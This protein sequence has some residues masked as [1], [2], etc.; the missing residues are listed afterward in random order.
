MM[1]DQIKNKRT[2]GEKYRK[3]GTP[4][5]IPREDRLCQC[6]CGNSFKCKINSKQR[7]ISGHN[8]RGEHW[9]QEV[10]D[11]ISDGHKGKKLSQESIK[12]RS[13]TIKARGSF[14]KENHPGW[15]PREERSCECGCGTTFICRQNSKRRFMILREKTTGL[16]PVDESNH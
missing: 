6:G 1:N 16:V 7:F 12:N 15:I 8:R 13:K 4:A 3:E 2:I 5:W 9:S 14:T 10:K 11:K